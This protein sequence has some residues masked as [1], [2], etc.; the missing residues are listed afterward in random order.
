ML[1]LENKYLDL[2][3]SHEF[4]LTQMNRCDPVRDNIIWSCRSPY[5]DR[6][7]CVDAN[8]R[9]TEDQSIYQQG[10]VLVGWTSWS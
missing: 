10:L 8:R 2:F 7:T 4:A 1:D 3:A 6:Q 9:L 5:L